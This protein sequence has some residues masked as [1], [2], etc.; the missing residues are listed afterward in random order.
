M[1]VGAATLAP[2][3][4]ASC[5]GDGKAERA[6]YGELVRD[7]GGVIDLPPRFQYRLLS[8]EGSRLSSG[9]PVP[10]HQDGM[11]AIPGKGGTTVLVRNHERASGHPGRQGQAVVGRRPFEAGELGGTTAIVVGPDRRKVED[12][13]T[14][15]GTRTNCAGGRTPWGTWLTCEEDRSDG[16]GYVFE[17]IPDEREGALSRSP[18]TDMGHFS[19]EA[20]AMDPRTGVVYLT[21]DDLAG[22]RSSGEAGE[23]VMRSFLYRYLPVDPSR[24]P[25][26]LQRG[27]RLQALAIEQSPSV[28]GRSFR[29][30]KRLGVVWRDVD[31]VRAHDDAERKGAARF[32]R[33]EGASLAHGALWFDDT[34]GGDRGLGQVYRYRPA[35]GTLELFFEGTERSEMRSPDN[36]VLTPWGDLWFAEDSVGG[37][38]RVMGITPQ[39]SVYVFARNRVSES[40]LAGLCFSPD[41][42][43]LFVNIYSPG[44]TLAIWGPFARREAAARRR[45]AIAQP[46]AALAPR[47]LPELAAAGERHGLSPLEAAAYDRLGVPLA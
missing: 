43:T 16:H 12:Y 36:V 6:G 27:G 47:G 9:A 19:H 3:Y 34:A 38:N 10:G 22:R 33:L 44:K 14:S 42:R 32:K 41:G 11:G 30:G 40:G 17:V 1:A 35:T 46:P 18:I 29:T 13:V 8:E 26:A 37:G 28:D 24:K 45:M 23:T 39:R 7:P 2:A 5:G 15:S 31:P 25:G 4:L 20:V 21:E